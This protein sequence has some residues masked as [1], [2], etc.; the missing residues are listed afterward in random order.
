[1]IARRARGRR[2]PDRR[3]AGALAQHRRGRHRP[4]RAPSR[5]A[6]VRRAGS[7]GPAANRQAAP[8]VHAWSNAPRRCSGEGVPMIATT[9]ATPSAAPTC[10]A[11]EFRPVAVAKLSPGAEATAAPLRLG[12]SVPAPM[13]SSTIPGSHSPRKSGVGADALDEP[14]HRAAPDQPAGDEHRPV[15]DALHEP[16]R[17]AGHGGG[18]ERPRRER[19]AGLEDRV[20]PHA[21]E[22][23]D[24]GQ[25]VAV[26]AGRGDDGHRV[27]GAERADPQQ[28][29]VDDRRA[30]PRA[31]PHEDRAEHDGGRERADDPRAA[32]APLLPLDHAQHERGDRQREQQRAERGR[33]SAGARG[34]G[35]RRGAGAPARSAAMPIGRLTRK[36]SRQSATATSRPPSEGPSPAAAAATADSSATPCE[37]RSGGNALQHERQRGR[38]RGSRRRAPA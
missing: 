33:A 19:E 20:A 31:A 4:A 28:R 10:R 24:V 36:T 29:Q 18:H 25:R 11:T 12:N 32:P 38:A 6:R 3:S 26:E 9:S 1:M 23:Q 30:M 34:R 5:P 8:N 7:R 2:R 14:Q 17:R 37:R 35:S 15:A 13:P 21:G 27:G 22:E 16:A